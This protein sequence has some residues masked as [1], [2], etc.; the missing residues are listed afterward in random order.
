MAVARS[1]LRF[2][3]AAANLT[4]EAKPSTSSPFRMSNP[5][6]LSQRKLRLGRS[7]VELSC[8]VDS[9]MPFHTATASAL[10]TSKLSVSIREGW[11]SQGLVDRFSEHF[12][13]EERID[14]LSI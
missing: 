6:S 11:L 13:K 1:V 3:N 7:P 4:S 12:E 9:L 14:G 8:C 2:R 10:L 5:K